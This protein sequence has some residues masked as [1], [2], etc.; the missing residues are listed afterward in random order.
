MIALARW[1]FLV[2]F[3]SEIGTRNATFGTEVMILL[4]QIH[5]ITQYWFNFRLYFVSRNVS[6]CLL[7]QRTTHARYYSHCFRPFLKQSQYNRKTMKPD[8][9]RKGIAAEGSEMS[10]SDGLLPIASP[11]S[12]DSFKLAP[13]ISTDTHSSPPSMRIGLVMDSI[14]ID[15]ASTPMPSTP[16]NSSA[17]TESSV[18]NIH[19]L[20]LEMR[21]RKRRRF[22][23]SDDGIIF[24]SSPTTS[25]SLPDLLPLEDYSDCHNACIPNTSFLRQKK[26]QRRRTPFM[27]LR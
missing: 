19:S 8:S 20:D 18:K 11:G 26:T 14:T 21:S 17:L 2:T 27:L 5:F 12:I 23:T 22:S 25:L 4:A 15:Q 24:C 3:L 6:H 13:R 16:M 10:S 1:N 7:S 9:F